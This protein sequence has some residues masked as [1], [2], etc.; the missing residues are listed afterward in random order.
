MQGLAAISESR[1]QPKGMK[2]L[3]ETEW[4]RSA[5]GVPEALDFCFSLG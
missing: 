4:L 3:C 2:N 1:N 5:S